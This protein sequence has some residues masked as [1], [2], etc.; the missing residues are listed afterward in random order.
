MATDMSLRRVLGAACSR[1]ALRAAIPALSGVSLAVAFTG[2]AMAQ[3]VNA[4]MVSATASNVSSNTGFAD[5]VLSK[6]K[7]QHQSQTVS[8]VTKAEM[9]L[10]TPNTSGLQT[11]TIKPGISISGYNSTSG[12]ARSTISM[13]GVKVGWNSV[14]GDLETNGVTVLLDGIPLNSL[15]QGTGWHSTEIPMGSLLSGSNVIFGPGNPQDRWYDSLGGTINF[16]PVQPTTQPE[17]GISAS[18]GSNDQMN[19]SL[20]ASSGVHD[21]WSSVLGYGY[22]SGNTFRTGGY[23]DPAHGNQLYAK[24]RKDFTNGH[25][26]IG[27]YWQHSAEQR[28]NDIPVNPIAGVTVAGLNVPG[29]QLY[30][31]QTSGFY[32][33]LPESVWFKKNQ[34][35]NY[36]GYFK[37]FDQL[38]DSTSVTNLTWYRH[39]AVIHY[40]INPGFQAASLN[41]SEYYNPHSDTFGDK[42]SFDTVLPYNTLSYGGYVIFA[43][44][45]NSYRGY[46]TLSYQ[47]STPS[48]QQLPY[49]ASQGIY[50]NLFAAAFVQDDISPIPALHIVPG[51]QL[52][53]FGTSFYNNN[54]SYALQYPPQQPGNTNPS[55]T[56][57]F[58]R[59]EPSIGVTYDI[60]PW[61]TPYANFAITYQN[62]TGGNFNNAQTDLPAL[63][64][65]KSTDYEIGIRMLQDHFIGFDEVSGSLGYFHDDL[66]DQTIPISL[67]SQ[68]NVTSFGYGS[69][70]LQ[71]VNAEF[72]GKINFN[73][74]VF[75]NAGYFSGHYTS[76]FSPGSGTYYSGVPVSN[77]PTLTSNIGFIYKRFVGQNL[78]TAS[79]FDQYFGHSY[80][81][82]N[83]I[84]APTKQKI[85]AYNLLNFNVTMSTPFFNRFVPK[86]GD[87]TFG[88]SGSN[89]L[90]RHYNSTEYVSAGGYFGGAGAGSVIANPGH[91][92]AVYGT[93]SMKF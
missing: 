57:D 38:D 45:V 25:F 36:I 18:Y 81:F 52:V 11:L 58:Q 73:W 9:N 5:Q 1:A 24:I 62:P 75:A 90:D 53:N 50:D 89:I 49:Q 91:G 37:F 84:Q 79:V 76:Y 55:V 88:I 77:T 31:Q 41:D 35:S 3:S 46:Q 27:T 28:P 2:L 47:G 26:S 10:F 68:P 39:G 19:V 67:A 74:E 8:T 78:I 6:K 93:V 48:S 51:L 72:N 70:A 42:L 21:G 66:T 56:K 15:I 59:P 40:R 13:R 22:A 64:P 17:A 92:R 63:K 44:T 43:H 71:G 4:G 83:L 32:S 20:Y 34:I 33:D 85:Q 61:L 16:I 87:L 12:T 54:A 60:F 14:P 86:L 29:A 23:N 69:A 65:V 30:S 82:S 7:V 80:M